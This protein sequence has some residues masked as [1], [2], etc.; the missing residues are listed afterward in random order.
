MSMRC[1]LRRISACTCPSGSS[2][3]WAPLSP[4]LAGVMLGA[5]TLRLRGD[6]LAIVTLGFGEI[7]RIFMNN[8]NA[9][10][11]HHQRPAGHQH[12]SIPSRSAGM[13][14]RSA[15]DTHGL[16]GGLTFQRSRSTTTISC[17]CCCW[18]SSDQSVRLQDS[19]IGRAWVAIRE[20]EVAAK[21]MRHQHAQHQAAGLRHGRHLRRRGRRLFAASRA[22]SAR[23]LRADRIHHGA[24]MVVLGGMGNICRRDPR[25]LLLSFCPNCCATR[26]AG[27][28]GAVR[29]V[30]VD[31]EVLRM[32]LFGWRWC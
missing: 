12:A 2:C 28:A 13:L 7:V 27:A 6:Y 31:P 24:A 8:L 17:C 5:P 15:S 21:A 9:P 14:C 3:R 1:W 10:G 30:L 23:E 25:R 18:R 20:D 29:Q 32:L 16:F 22:S 4:A 11:Q 19:R 26:G